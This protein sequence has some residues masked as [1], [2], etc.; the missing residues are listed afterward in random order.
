MVRFTID[1]IKVST[2]E[3]LDVD[4]SFWRDVFKPMSRT[5]SRIAP[6]AG[7]DCKVPAEKT[8]QPNDGK[9]SNYLTVFFI[10]VGTTG[11]LMLTIY[12]IRNRKKPY[13]WK[14]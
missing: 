14:S 11:G 5:L 6:S 4:V 3:K 2:S 1:G 8:T 10:L 12:L 9:N 7:Q 13:V